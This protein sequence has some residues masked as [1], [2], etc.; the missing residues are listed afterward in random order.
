MKV[1]LLGLSN[2][3]T[4]KRIESVRERLLKEGHTVVV[5]QLLDKKT[6]GK[7]R[8]DLWNQWM[9]DDFEEIYD[10]SGG[11]LANETIPY[12]DLKAYENSKATFFGYSDLTCVLN[13]LA[14]IRPCVLYQICNGEFDTQFK[15]EFFEGSN[16]EG[17]V[18][19]GNIR[20]LLKLAGTPYFPDCK[21]K[22]LFL[23]SYSGNENRIRTYFAQLYLMGVFDQIKGLL[24]GQ[25]TELDTDG[26]DLSFL[27][28]YYKGNIARTMDIGH[29]K[30]AKGLWIGKEI[31]L[32]RE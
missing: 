30:D 12:L 3:C 24:L 8:A 7:Q 25:F 26:N 11:D 29:S 20:C 28:E 18:V 17:I 2:P 27:R 19:G 16:L 14:T 6:S 9:K 22:I 15:Y 4:Y 21:D 32:C 31:S 5:S 10:V 23:E 1:G 13:I